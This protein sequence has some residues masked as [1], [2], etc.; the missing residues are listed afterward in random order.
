MTEGTSTKVLRTLS[1]CIFVL[2][3]VEPAEALNP[4]RQVYQLGHRVWG[5]KHGYPPTGVSLLRL[6]RGRRQ[7]DV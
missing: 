3:L 2:L 6:F 4:D 5:E 1:I 7:D